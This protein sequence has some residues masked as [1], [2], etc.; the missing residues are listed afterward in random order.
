MAKKVVIAAA[1]KEKYT[2]YDYS[3]L[4]P[5]AE[6]K[7]E[8]EHKTEVKPEKKERS[9]RN[10]SKVPEGYK[11]N[12]DCIEKKSRRVQLILQPSLFEK[13]TAKAKASGKSFNDY[14][15]TLLEEDINN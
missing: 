15:H 4:T 14:V 9:P 12:P 8:T 13:V 3:S 6:V 7:A 5:Q 10:A 1:T 2:G 11:L